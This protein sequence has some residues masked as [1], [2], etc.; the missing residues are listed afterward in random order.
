MAGGGEERLS[1]LSK[2]KLSPGIHPDQGIIH[3]SWKKYRVP[4]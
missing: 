2:D 1:T 4:W 3:N